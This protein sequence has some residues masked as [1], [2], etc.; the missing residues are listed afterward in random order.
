M[1]DSRLP[2]EGD[3]VTIKSYKHDGSLHRTWR[4]TMVLKTSENAIIGLNDHTLVTEDDGRRWVTREPAIVYFHRKYWFN[5]VAMIRDNGVSYYCNLAS[6]FVLDKEALKYVD[7][8]L[9]VKVFPNGEKRLLDTD[10]YELHK[11][12]WRYPADIDYIVREHVKILVDWI[13]N[14]QGPFSDAYIDLWYRRYLEIK[15]RNSQQ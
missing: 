13:D 3:F 6:P 11:A 9:D 14:Q 2:R 1:K 8:D 15:R 4:D 5:I 12:H 7:Y 10:E